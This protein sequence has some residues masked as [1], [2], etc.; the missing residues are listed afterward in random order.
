MISIQ[1]SSR[2]RKQ[3][4]VRGCVYKGSESSQWKDHPRITVSSSRSSNR[5]QSLVTQS[6]SP[7]TFKMQSKFLAALALAVFPALSIAA[8][9]PEAAA[10]EPTT[11][12]GTTDDSMFTP[13]LQTLHFDFEN[14]MILTYRQLSEALLPLLVNSLTRSPFSLATLSSV[15]VSCSTPTPS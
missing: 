11:D 2:R 1:L 15:V 4:E 14:Y 8:A 9:I 5:L 12:V 6:L 13:T 10:V 7:T 3:E